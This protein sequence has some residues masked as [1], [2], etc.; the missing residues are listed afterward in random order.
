MKCPYCAEEIEDDAPSCRHCGR[1]LAR[2]VVPVAAGT[3]PPASEWA[4]GPTAAPDAPL[5][6]PS[7][8]RSIR[9]WAFVGTAAALLG[10]LWLTVFLIGRTSE[11]PPVAPTITAPAPPSLAEGWVWAEETED[12]FAIG[13]PQ[14]WEES[15]FDLGETIK[16]QAIDASDAASALEFV[17]NLNII[18]QP[19]PL[20]L[21][22][23]DYVQANLSQLDVQVEGVTA[24]SHERITLPVGPTERIE[25][26]FDLGEGEQVFRIS[27]LQFVFIDDGT[28]YVVTFETK[29]RQMDEYRP[30]F[31]EMAATFRFTD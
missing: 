9:T 12:G 16:F 7:P 28:G 4:F 25:Y 19:L 23:D 11:E 15:Q 10:V 24:L 30:T 31:E 27:V 29:P 8:P 2:A 20:T 17:P 22:L 5:Q 13:L 26:I 18:A 6:T 1:V 3:G 21:S 14:G